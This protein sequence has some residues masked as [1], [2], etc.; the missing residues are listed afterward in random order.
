LLVELPVTCG[1]RLGEALASRFGVFSD[2]IWEIATTLHKNGTTGTPKTKS[3][4]RRVPV[5]PNLMKKI[6]ERRLKLGAGPDDF[7]FA[8]ER[9]KKPMSATNFRKRGWNKAVANA[10]LNDGA[11]KIRPPDARHAAASQLGARLSSADIGRVLA[12]Q[13]R[14]SRSACICTSST[15]M[16]PRNAYARRWVVVRRARRTATRGAT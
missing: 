3:S 12:T 5:P 15:A 6:V 7:V 14:R 4:T 2:G 10:D 9:G 13:A 8:T 1:P 16:R 11:P